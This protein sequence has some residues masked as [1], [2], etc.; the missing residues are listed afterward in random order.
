LKTKYKIYILDLLD[1]VLT[2]LFVLGAVAILFPYFT[3]YGGLDTSL[4]GTVVFVFVLGLLKAFIIFI[5]GNKI[6]FINNL[7]STILSK[8]E[9]E[10]NYHNQY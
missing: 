8:G 10:W 2:I 3:Y 5:K 7:D 4:L 9:S 1:Y 6:K